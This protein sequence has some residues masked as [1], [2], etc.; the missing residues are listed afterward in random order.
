MENKNNKDTI[1]KAVVSNNQETLLNTAHKTVDGSSIQVTKNSEGSS[2]IIKKIH[3]LQ[4]LKCC[5]YAQY[6]I[7]TSIFNFK[8]VLIAY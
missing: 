8:S 2:F 5:K 6:I 3:I 1:K 4:F 7:K